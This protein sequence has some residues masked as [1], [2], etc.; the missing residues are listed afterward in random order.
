MSISQD[1][2]AHV[3]DAQSVHQDPACLHLSGDPA[4]ILREL[5][6]IARG[7]EQDVLLRHADGL[8]DL[9][10]GLAVT[11]LAVHRNR[12]LRPQQG[13]HQLDL[14]SAGMA[15]HMGILEQDLGA[16]DGELVDHTVHRLLIARDRVRTHDDHVVGADG[17]LPVISVRHPGKSRHALAL[18]SCGDQHRLLRRIVLQLLDIDQG[19][20]RD[21]DVAQFVGNTDD[22]H[23]G[24]P[25]DHHLPAVLACRVDDLL[26]AVHIGREGRHDDPL[27]LVFRKDNVEGPAHRP[28]R[29]GKAGTDRVGAV[30]EQRQHA[31]SA[32]LRHSL[33]IRRLAEHRRIVYLE[34]SGVEDDSRRAEDRQGGAVGDG[35]VRLDEFHVEVP[36]RDRVAVLH[37]EQLRGIRDLVFLQ[38][39]ADEGD[40]KPRRIDRHVQLL[41]DIGQCADMVLVS[42]GDDKALHLGR[43]VLQIGNVRDDAVYTRHILA[44]ERD[45]AVHHDDAVAVLKGGDV[46]ADLFQ[47]AQGD[48]LYRGRCIRADLSGLSELCRLQHG[49]DL[50]LQFLCLFQLRFLLRRPCRLDLFPKFCFDLLPLRLFRLCFS[51]LLLF[52][53]CG[54]SLLWLLLLLLRLLSGQ[55]RLCS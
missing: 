10:L 35:M 21:P 7:H 23:H 19:V 36:Q 8:R 33:Q 29:H 40:G 31:V 28:L 38:L 2:A 13:V 37:H 32:Q 11:V 42:V 9:H 54:F 24:T 45:A 44:G 55:I 26:D 25:L 51:D 14:L 3:P 50:R 34:I 16:L 18:A 47:T 6:H 52:C 43:V 53:L 15:G 39:P 48:D 17:H 30:A 27:I 12:E 5:D 1:D 41:Q 49:S 4:G 22:V 20:L 46:H